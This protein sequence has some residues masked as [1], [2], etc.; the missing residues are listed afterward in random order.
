LNWEQKKYIW[1]GFALL[2]ILYF[3]WGEPETFQVDSEYINGILTAL[4]I[5]Y[6]FW[7]MMLGKE[8]KEFFERFRYKYYLRDLIYYNVELLFF[9]ILYVFLNAMRMIP[10][11]LTLILLTISFLFN[12]IFLGIYLHHHFES[13]EV[14]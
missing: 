10:S 5:V 4:S 14:Y 6:G 2:F 8:P 12:I 3:Y 11:Y 13:I 7:I 1:V 9:S